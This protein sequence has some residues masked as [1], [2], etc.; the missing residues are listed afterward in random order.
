MPISSTA[1]TSTTRNKQHLPAAFPV[2]RDHRIATAA[3]T[4]PA[5]IP[6]V[7][8]PTSR[9]PTFSDAADLLRLELR[10]IV[11]SHYLYSTSILPLR[12]ARADDDFQR[13]SWNH[14]EQSLDEGAA[15]AA[16]RLLALQ[17]TRRA[18]PAPQLHF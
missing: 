18:A 8:I 1:T 10:R 11:F 7:A 3:P 15:A 14:I 13:F 5:L 12:A 4:R 2:P 17:V 6:T 9:L 16:A